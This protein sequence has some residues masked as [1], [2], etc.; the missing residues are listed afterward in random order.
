MP[1]PNKPDMLP[2]RTKIVR[3][4]KIPISPGLVFVEKA[5]LLGL[6]FGGAYFQRGLLLDGILRFKMG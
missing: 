6:F 4:R 5:F 3:Y 2:K 1:R